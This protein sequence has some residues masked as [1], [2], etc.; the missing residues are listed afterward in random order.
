MA[1]LPHVN[2]CRL[3]FSLGSACF[4]AEYSS[5]QDLGYP[6]GSCAV[7]LGYARTSMIRFTTRNS[8]IK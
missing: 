8:L 7:V 2:G 5:V 6:Y 1:R 3:N 4:F